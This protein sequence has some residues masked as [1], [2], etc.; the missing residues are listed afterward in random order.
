MSAANGQR[1]PPDASLLTPNDY[2]RLRVAL[3]GRDPAEV[4]GADTFEDTMQGLILAWKLREDPAFTWD[5]A[6]DVPPAEVF[7]M[8]GRDAEPDPPTGGPGSPGPE[9][10]PP[11]AKASS[12]K[13]PGR[14]SALR[15]ASS[16]D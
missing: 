9:P 7:D 3:G 2:R 11:A 15:S 1:P 10:A 6:G 5:Q 16:S 8:S 12:R 14:V 13:Q 4:L